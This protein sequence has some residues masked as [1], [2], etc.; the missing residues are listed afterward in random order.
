MKKSKRFAAI[1]IAA[2]MTALGVGT[3]MADPVDPPTPATRSTHYTVPVEGTDIADNGHFVI[4]ES[5]K[6]TE[7]GT[8]LPDLKYTLTLGSIQGYSTTGTNGAKYHFDTNTDN[9]D[10]QK[11]Y[12]KTLNGKAYTVEYKANENLTGI[13]TVPDRPYKDASGNPY[14]DFTG[15]KFTEPGIYYWEVM[16]TKTESGGNVATNNAALDETD[17]KFYLVL[18]IDD[19]NGVLKP[20]VGLVE[21]LE[22]QDDKFDKISDQYPAKNVDLN[23]HKKVT[24]NQG[25]K[26]EYFKVTVNL[27]DL[28]AY[29]GQ[30]FNVVIERARNE[31]PTTDNLKY[32]EEVN[33]TE[34]NPV[35]ITI[36]NNGKA[37]A[38][39]WMKHDDEVI[40]KNLPSGAKYTVTEDP[41]DYT[42]TDTT[43]KPAYTNAE[44]AAKQAEIDAKTSAITTKTNQKENSTDAEEIAA[45][46][47]EIAQLEADKTALTAEKERMQNKK[48]DDPTTGTIQSTEVF[49]GFTNEKKTATPTGIFLAMGPGLT[50]LILAG[51]GLAVVGVSRR[52]REDD[53]ED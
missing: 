10:L 48:H 34:H 31:N 26:D 3:A 51:A 21:K 6:I 8:R 9:T 52:K 20:T 13:Q 46:E 24:G 47:A 44:I 29:K 30:K 33:Q 23:I 25:S 1:A 42:K 41:K 40:I 49:T 11:D 38:I 37:E 36:D 5:L 43:D 35:E 14:I 7:E 53:M 45:L 17:N 27:E 19:V 32:G 18:R 22:G 16:K 28:T 50:T 15:F 12:N 39:F 4:N 2:V